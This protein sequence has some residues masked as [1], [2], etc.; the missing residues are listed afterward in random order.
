MKKLAA[1]FTASQEEL[2]GDLEGNTW[3][4]EDALVPKELQ[5][6]EQAHADVL[7]AHDDVV[8]AAD[9]VNNIEETS[10]L[11]QEALDAG[12]AALALKIANT[13]IGAMCRR[14]GLESIN[15]KP[16][17]EEGGG[18]KKAA[19]AAWDVLVK[20]FKA[21]VAAIKN[22]IRTLSIYFNTS[23]SEA[24]KIKARLEKSKLTLVHLPKGMASANAA[25]GGSWLSTFVSSIK[26][27]IKTIG[28]VGNDIKAGTNFESE[29]Q[30]VAHV[31]K[32]IFEIKWDST[33]KGSVVVISDLSIKLGEDATVKTSVSK[34]IAVKCLESIVE[35]HRNLLRT[36]DN[37]EKVEEEA[38]TTIEKHITNVDA[39]TAEQ[40]EAFVHI[41]SN[42]RKIASL[43][44]LTAKL[45]I[46][47]W[48]GGVKGLEAE[49]N[50]L[51]GKSS[52]D[53]DHENR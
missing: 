13:G 35:G 9:V 4:G 24:K 46:T 40:R 48:S 39:L 37:M 17:L 43:I 20:A 1:M 33:K 6:V 12:N 44:I 14:V 22:F 18:L 49:L 3:V 34:S 16:S 23:S 41:Q 19:A 53:G 36:L 52:K 30:Q 5:A 27:D 32:G 25:S 50:R 29:A 11:S 28:V 2:R 7:D 42:H 15:L 51:E 47:L 21:A 10:E 26:D 31:T 8:E 38:V 45:Y